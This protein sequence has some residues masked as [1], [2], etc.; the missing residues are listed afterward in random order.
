MVHLPS[1][2]RQIAIT[3]VS[4]GVPKLPSV[5]ISPLFSHFV[6]CFHI[7]AQHPHPSPE[8]TGDPP[9]RL[10]LPLSTFYLRSAQRKVLS[11]ILSRLSTHPRETSFPFLLDLRS[12]FH[13]LC[14]NCLFFNDIHLAS[15]TIIRS[16]LLCPI[17]FI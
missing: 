7:S 1:K 14:L 8:A 16:L 12:L 9:L 13:L 6:P 11:V 10:C 17:S 5:S 15:I 3:R 2:S 4:Q